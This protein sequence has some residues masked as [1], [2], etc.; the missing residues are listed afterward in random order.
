MLPE[1]AHVQG[2]RGRLL[3]FFGMNLSASIIFAASPTNSWTLS[4]STCNRA[5]LLLPAPL[6]NCVLPMNVREKRWTSA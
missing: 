4:I 2:V 3:P 6:S 5:P 1:V